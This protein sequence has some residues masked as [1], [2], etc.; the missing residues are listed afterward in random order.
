MMWPDIPN[1]WCPA[2]ASFSSFFLLGYAGLR[3]C[4]GVP[5]QHI[6]TGD[7]AMPF[8]RLDDHERR[9][10]NVEGKLNTIEA[11]MVEMHAENRVRADE[12]EQRHRA[13]AASTREAIERVGKRL[14]G[15]LSW[16]SVVGWAVVTAS[17]AG[18]AT[19]AAHLTAFH[20]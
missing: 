16:R 14:D 8:E 12:R 2:D 15:A 17:S 18:V 13:D 20:P 19:A 9:L 1:F 3:A 4:A 7:A 11:R 10:A 6:L 5:P